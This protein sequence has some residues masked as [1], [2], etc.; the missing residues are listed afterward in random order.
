MSA[1]DAWEALL[2]IHAALVPAIAAEVEAA[3]GLPLS[4]YDVLLELSGAPDRRLRMQELGERVVLSRS[5]VSRIVD[6]M[7]AAGL[8]TKRPD[9]DDGRATL[10]VLTAAGRR[11]QRRAAPVYLAAI[12]RRF[13]AH[14]P[15]AATVAGALLQVL[16]ADA[17]GAGS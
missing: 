3:T 10:A 6:E 13:G 4:W 5:R 15:D 11:A 1:T 14:L 9:P 12:E 2:R 8:V 17:S 16:A 7:M